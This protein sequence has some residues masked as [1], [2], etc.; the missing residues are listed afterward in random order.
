MLRGVSAANPIRIFLASGNAHKVAELRDLAA[1]AESYRRASEQ[2]RAPYY[3]ARLHAEVLRR[4]GRNAEALKWLR[5][6]HP[7]LPKNDEAAAADVVLERIR[8]LERELE[9]PAESRYQPQR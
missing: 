1:G 5:D 2:P 7:R 3:A 8:D 4:Q 6:L 9:V